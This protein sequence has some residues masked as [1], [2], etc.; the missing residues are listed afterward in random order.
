MLLPCPLNLTLQFDSLPAFGA[1]APLFH[2]SP[3]IFTSLLPYLVL[4]RHRDEKPVTASP[5]DSVL[6]NCDARNSFRIR[7]YENCRVSPGSLIKNLKFY[8][9]FDLSSHALCSLFSLFAERAKHY[10]FILSGFRT[11]SKNAG[12]YGSH[13]SSQKLFSLFAPSPVAL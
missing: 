8:L 9:R 1:R 2:L 7:S 10:F 4:D 6:T 13:P 11:A 5:L 12:V 3:Y